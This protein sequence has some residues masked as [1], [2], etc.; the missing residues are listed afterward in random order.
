[1][2]RIPI[3]W[4]A[5][6][7]CWFFSVNVAVAVVIDTVTVGDPGNAD[8]PSGNPEFSFGG[9]G[10]EYGIGTY[11]VTNAQYAAFLNAKAASDTLGLY[12]PSMGTNYVGGI[13]RSGIDGSYTYATRPNMADKPV[14][15]VD[16]F[17]SIRFA[18]RLHNGQGVGDTETGSYT[19]FGGTPVPSNADSIARTARPRGC[20]RTETSGLR[21]HTTI[22]VQAPKAGRGAATAIGSIPLKVTIHQRSLSLTRLATSA[23]PGPVWPIPTA[24]HNGQTPRPM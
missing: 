14:L 20:C 2:S 8:A 18:N 17:D 10:Y 22:P 7:A 21:R 19:L 9:V 12:N 15:F 11:E 16:Y 23:I 4:F 13:T 1:M 6:S 24:L 5:L 3:L